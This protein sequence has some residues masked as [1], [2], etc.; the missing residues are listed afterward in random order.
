MRYFDFRVAISISTV[1]RLFKQVGR[2]ERQICDGD[3]KMSLTRRSPLAARPRWPRARQGL[4][5]STALVALGGLSLGTI[6]TARS[7][8]A[9]AVVN[10]AITAADLAAA[11]KGWC[12][13]L[14]Q[15]AQT[16]A[17]RGGAAA[18]ALAE[19][20]IDSA[21]GYQFGAVLFKPTLTTAPQTF[22]TTRAGA[23]AYFVGGDPAFPNDSGFALNGW[24][25]CEVT[26]AAVFIA[27]NTAT[28]MGNVTMTDGNGRVT[29]VDKTWQFVKD[30]EGRLRMVVHHSSLP[31]SRN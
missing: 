20:V 29:T 2:T 23:L 15:I 26:D 22:R 11:Q 24:T 18:R 27:G 5:L 13:A 30:G 12:D 1:G 25:A 4:C 6:A 10:Q 9:P 21:Y 19:T 8:D 31:H 17:T 16:N 14:I 3:F 28:T 7:A